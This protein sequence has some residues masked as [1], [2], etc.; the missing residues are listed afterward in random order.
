LLLRAVQEP[1]HTKGTSSVVFTNPGISS[2]LTASTSWGAQ[3]AMMALV[4]SD[5]LE[6]YL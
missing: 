4:A 3:V 5:V 6:R 2:F 1:I